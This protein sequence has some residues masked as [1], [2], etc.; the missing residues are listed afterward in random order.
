[1]KKILL[2]IFIASTLSGCA[3]TDKKA[4]DDIESNLQQGNT[5][6]AIA[7]AIEHAVLDKENNQ[8]GDQLWGMQ[9]ASLLRMNKQY[10]QSNF[11]FDLIEDVMYQEDTENLVIEGAEVLGS[12]ITN[13]SFLSYEQ[14]MYDSIMVNTYKAINF[15]AQSDFANARVEW[16]RSDDRQRRAADYFA[17]K[18]NKTKKDI[19]AKEKKS[20]N[21][22]GTK[23]E[24]NGDIDKSVTQSNIILATKGIDMSS[25]QAYE[26]YINPFSTYMHGLFFMLKAQDK[27]DIGKAID[28]FKRVNA[29]AKNSVT[30]ESLALA[31]NIQKGKQKLNNINKVWVIYENGQMAKKQEIRIDLPIFLVSNNVAYTG[32]ALPSLTIQPDT[33]GSLKVQGVETEIVAD[34]DK[35]IQAEF[36]EEF[37]LILTREIIRTTAKTIIQKQLNDENPLLGYGAGIL[38]ALSTQADLRTWSLLP[39]NFQVAVIDKP[40][41]NQ[42]TL[43]TGGFHV[44]FTV[45]LTPNKNAIIYVKSTYPQIQ[46]SVEVIYL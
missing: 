28:S 15:M 46:P 2:T 13:D 23:A 20:K 42:V 38:Q 18:I 10:K 12:I 32:I 24:N 45:D 17:K 34:M 29:I 37:P 16:N 11:Y 9:T 35:I 31:R 3:S 30:M 21:K 8:L 7:V 33:F 36:K 14:T 43:E 22:T 44:P 19:L 25:W 27:T 6:Q 40:K 5:K 41:N 4:S 39:K 26:G 1:M